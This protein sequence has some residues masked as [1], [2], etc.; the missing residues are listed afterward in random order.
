[1][2]P[3]LKDC[4]CHFCKTQY[5]SKAQKDRHR[6]ALH[7]NQRADAIELDLV[8][9]IEQ[10]EAMRSVKYVIDSRKRGQYLCVLQ[11]NSLKWMKL[12]RTNQI[13]KDYLEQVKNIEQ[14]DLEEAAWM[15]DVFEELS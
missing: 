5:P 9:R 7:K 12:K 2:I 8:L 1:M 11:D 15:R 10:E 14:F 4:I 3:K 6:R 13:V